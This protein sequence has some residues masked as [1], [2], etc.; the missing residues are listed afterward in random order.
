VDGAGVDRDGGYGGHGQGES[1][2]AEYG[3]QGGFG[4]GLSGVQDR[5]RRGQGAGG[6][7]ASACRTTESRP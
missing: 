2:D 5:A 4:S 7:P 3:A 6:S 1:G